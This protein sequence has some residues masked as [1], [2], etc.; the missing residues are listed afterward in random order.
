ML[1]TVMFVPHAF[2]QSGLTY[3]FTI[4]SDVDEDQ[5]ITSGGRIKSQSDK[6]R[7]DVTTMMDKSFGNDEATIL[8]LDNGN[9]VIMLNAQKKSYFELP[10]LDAMGSLAGG[11]IKNEASNVQMDVKRVGAGPTILGYATV[12]Y[13]MTQS[14]D[15]TTSIMGQTQK[16]REEIMMDMY[17]APA[18]KHLISAPM[19]R[20]QWG[21]A[22]MNAYGKEYAAKQRELDGKFTNEGLPLKIS[23]VT[24]TT[25][26]GKTDS[27][28]MIFEITKLT[29]GDVPA[30]EFEIPAGFTKTE[31]PKMPNL[32]SLDIKKAIGDA[33]GGAMGE[34]STQTQSVGDAAK[35]GVK[36]G[37]AETKKEAAEATKEAA[38][39]KTK[40]AI[41]GLF[42]KP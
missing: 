34:A 16:K 27:S 5:T 17:I 9:R 32:D 42:G 14:M 39:T 8:V 11:M 36:E 20:M 22:A 38:K 18:L 31:L 3:E 6:M 28:T 23:G 25:A 13:R 30:S 15:V 7:M 19:G 21:A 33:L 40:K 29:T 26:D 10:S 4:K 41:R 12:Q 1:A 35:A 2:A 37:A 24:K